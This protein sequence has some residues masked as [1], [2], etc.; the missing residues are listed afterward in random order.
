MSVCGLDFGTSNTTL[1][2]I[3]G[4]APVLAAAA[5]HKRVHARLR[6]ARKRVH[7]RLR[8]ARK[9]VHARLRRAMGRCTAGPRHKI[10]KT[11]PCKVKWAPARQH[12]CCVAFGAREE[13]W[14]VVT[15]H[16]A[17]AMSDCPTA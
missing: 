7:A 12:S 13:K 6:H 2:T 11:T 1:G 10:A 17:L 8:H 4:H 15:A 9:R 14:S 3:E 5:P 16:P